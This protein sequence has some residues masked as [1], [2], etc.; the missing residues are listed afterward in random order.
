[1]A[2]ATILL[3]MAAVGPS[4]DTFTTDHTSSRTRADAPADPAARTSSTLG[5]AVQT[6]ADYSTA[7]R[8]RTDAAARTI[9]Q[10]EAR[11]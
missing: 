4:E 10:K 8:A 1:M 6:R 7:Q 11:H 2:T 9:A 5:R 3:T